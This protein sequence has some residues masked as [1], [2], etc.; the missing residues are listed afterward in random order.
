MSNTNNVLASG[1][2]IIGT[3]KF[4]NDMNI[5]GRVEGEISSDTGKVTIAEQARI[6]GDIKAGEVHVYGNVEG[7]VQSERCHLRGCAVING[8]IVT[9]RLSMEEGAQLNGRVT[10]G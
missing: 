1:I 3:I 4:H 9:Q 6:K 7:N 10:V 5:D 8:D 2:E